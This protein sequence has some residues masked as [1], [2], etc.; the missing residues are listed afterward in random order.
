MLL[1]DSLGGNA[2]TQIFINA[3]PTA[4]NLTETENSLMYGT[5]A[6][7]IKNEST[8]NELNK[9]M[10]K[11]KKAVDHWKEQAGLTPEQRSRVDLMPIQNI[12]QI[13]EE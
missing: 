7:A 1:S 12:R 6:R 5:N 9:E 3:I 13:G 4:A 11:L 10:L 2:K 8:K